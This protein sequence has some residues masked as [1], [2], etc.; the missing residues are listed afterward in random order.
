MS[1]NINELIHSISIYIWPMVRLSGF[2]ISLPLI[3]SAV[4]PKKVRVIFVMYLAMIVAPSHPEWPSLL[5][6][7]AISV[8]GLAQEFFIGVL[9]GFIIQFVFQSFIL[10]GQ[11][12]A[13]QAG[14][15]FATLIDPAS[16]ASVP[17]VSQFYLMLVTLVFLS[18]DGHLLMIEMVIKSFTIQPLGNTT[19]GINTLWAFIMFSGWIFKGAIFLALPAIVSLLVVSLSFGIMMKAAPQINIFSVGFPITLILGIVIVYVS[20]QNVLPNIKSLLHEAFN[21]ASEMIRHV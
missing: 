9:M 8:V 16:K 17:L 3:S 1:L 6:F 18:L 19:I 20:M 4:T 5:S 13:M 7:S 15:G 12:L 14:L 21:T 2:V 11:V 10:G